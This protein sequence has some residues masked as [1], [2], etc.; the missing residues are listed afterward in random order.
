MKRELRER[1]HDVR[2]SA[3]ERFGSEPDQRNVG[4]GKTEIVL[5]FA[6]VIGATVLARNAL[7]AVWRTALECDSPMNLASL[8]VVRRD[9]LVWG[10]F[11][12]ALLG[13]MRKASRRS[14][15]NVCSNLVSR[16]GGADVR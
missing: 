15:S 2:G 16:Y 14:L 1:F 10:A 3:E 8:E 5:S 6:M 7:Q 4:I 9:V 11:S 12:G 13:V